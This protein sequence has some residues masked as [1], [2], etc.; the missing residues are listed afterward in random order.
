MARLLMLVMVVVAM[1]MVAEGRNFARQDWFELLDKSKSDRSERNK[2]FHWGYTP[3]N[4]KF[5]LAGLSSNI[6]SVKFVEYGQ[7]YFSQSKKYELPLGM[8]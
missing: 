6:Y 2:E 3:E 8:D 4:G 7:S 5:L 1:E